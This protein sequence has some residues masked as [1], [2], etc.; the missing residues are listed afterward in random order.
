MSKSIALKPTI[1]EGEI[2]L[3][4]HQCLPQSF[5]NLFRSFGAFTYPPNKESGTNSAQHGPRNK[6]SR[7]P[8]R[9]L[10]TWWWMIISVLTCLWSSC[11]YSPVHTPHGPTKKRLEVMSPHKCRNQFRNRRRY[12]AYR[13]PSIEETNQKGRGDGRCL[14][15][16]QPWR[17]HKCILCTRWVSVPW[18]LYQVC[19]YWNFL[20]SGMSTI[21]TSSFWQ[22]VMRLTS[23]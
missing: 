20:C 9:S 5:P 10:K 13:I 22:E 17:W 23:I 15:N 4:R 8:Y 6:D 12:L 19:E 21:R 11:G 2:E 14:A 18:A 1:L 7:C 3:F 16:V